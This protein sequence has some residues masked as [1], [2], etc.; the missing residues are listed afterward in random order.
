MAETYEPVGSSNIG[1]VT[2]EK[3]TGEMMIRFVDG[4]A[5]TYRGVPAELYSGMQRASS[6][7][8]Y[9]HRHIRDRYPY[10]QVE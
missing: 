9:F 6:A 8:G 1:S 5:Y 2:Y 4:A 3:T 7:G 10:E